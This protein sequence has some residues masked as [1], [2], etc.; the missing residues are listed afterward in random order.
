[1]RRVNCA[2]LHRPLFV[3]FFSKVASSMASAYRHHPPRQ[4]PP[5]EQPNDRR[6][7]HRYPVNVASEYKVVLRDRTVLA[8]IGH[9]VNMSSRGILLDTAH[10]LPSG[11]RIDLSIAWPALLNDVAPLKLEVAGKTIRTQGGRAAVVIRRYEFR[12]RG[13]SKDG[14]SALASCART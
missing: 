9:T 14:L 8:G 1:M 4:T 3:E 6:S 11:V 10:C 12:T 2:I 7:N 5:S 13:K